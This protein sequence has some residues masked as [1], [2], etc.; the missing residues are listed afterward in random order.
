MSR[1]LLLAVLFSSSL[2][3]DDGLLTQD[4]DGQRV[5]VRIRTSTEFDGRRASRSSILITTVDRSTSKRVEIARG[6][7]AFTILDVRDG[8]FSIRLDLHGTDNAV[9]KSESLVTTKEQVEFS[10]STEEL[11]VEGSIS[12]K[13]QD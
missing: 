9:L 1:L 13:I 3:A 8:E 5:I 6:H 7:I 12:M 11:A 2:T 10:F 4:L